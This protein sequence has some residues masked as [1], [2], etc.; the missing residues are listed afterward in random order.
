MKLFRQRL[1][2]EFKTENLEEVKTKLKE[3][4]S[5]WN[6]ELEKHWVEKERD[7]NYFVGKVLLTKDW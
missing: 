4:Y 1:N 6:I 3:E 2:I 7:G 5:D